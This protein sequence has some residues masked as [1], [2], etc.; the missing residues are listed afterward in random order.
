MT[1][2]S[3]ASGT[4]GCGA[5]QHQTP[6][7]WF[8]LQWPPSWASVSIAAKEL[9]PVVAS[10]AMWGGSWTKSR[11]VFQC[12]NMATVQV[13]SSGSS[14][15][16]TMARLLR[17]LFFFEAYYGFEHEAKHVRGVDNVAADA[18]SRNRADLFLSLL[19]HAGSPI[20]HAATLFVGSTPTGH[21]ALLDITS[22][23]QLVSHYF[24]G[25][26][27][28]RTRS[29][30]SSAQRRYLAFCQ[31]YHLSPLPLSEYNVCLFAALLASEGCLYSLDWTTG[32]E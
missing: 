29:S 15:D 31:T 24:A 27:A 23:E 22:L 3:D 5:F 32:M 11:V 16:P 26:L 7:K 14:R 19:P 8:Q 21:R 18:L 6:A 17:C 25:G 30:Y 13:L 28:Q 20:T 10:A 12:D 4:W 9:F 1:V 2:T